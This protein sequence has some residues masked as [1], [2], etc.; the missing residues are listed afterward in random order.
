MT[1]S[2]V[3]AAAPDHIR[4][5]IASSIPIVPVE[6]VT[7]NPSPNNQLVVFNPPPV[8]DQQRRSA[9]LAELEVR[10]I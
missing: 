10:T 8:S 9:L 2:I 1:S 3:F 7:A 4:D 6:S 5:P